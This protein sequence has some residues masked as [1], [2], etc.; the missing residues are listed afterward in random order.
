M[1]DEWDQYKAAPADEWA[2]YKKQTPSDGPW[3]ILTSLG[4]TLKYG[5]DTATA[6][7]QSW[8]AALNPYTIP[9][10]V[11]GDVYNAS[12]EQVKKGVQS[13]KEGHPFRGARQIFPGALP[14]VG[15]LI[16]NSSEKMTSGR[17]WEGATDLAQALI[18]MLGEEAA[19]SP[20]LRG[21]AKT[22]K[23]KTQGA[24]Q[25]AKAGLGQLQGMGAI[26]GELAQAAAGHPILGPIA[27]ALIGDAFSGFPM[28]RGAV[29]GAIDAK[30][31]P[32]ATPPPLPRSIPPIWEGQG[33]TGAPMPPMD[34]T[35]G[36]MPAPK[37]PSGRTP[38]A[39]NPFPRPETTPAPN[40][41]DSATAPAAASPT[42]NLTPEQFRRDY[43]VHFDIRP[44]DPLTR[45]D[46]MMKN[47]VTGSSSMAVPWD[48]NAPA[49]QWP[50]RAAKPG[51]VAY[52]FDKNSYAN[53]NTTN[54]KPG[55]KPVDYV[56][57][58]EGESPLD[59]L[60]RKSMGSSPTVNVD[61]SHLPHIGQEARD[62]AAAHES[63]KNALN[64][65][66]N[67]SKFLASKNW[68]PENLP[69][70][71]TPQNVKDLNAMVQE[72][73]RANKTNHSLFDLS[74][75]DKANA[76]LNLLRMVL[77]DTLA[78]PPQ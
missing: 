17:P 70:E 65:A 25:G 9:N 67:I 63:P 6:P 23:V 8:E 66:N 51:S 15:P 33:P 56:I 22:V 29:R 47:G 62:F 27:G 41:P 42:V 50:K 26:A 60:K 39:Y 40:P 35:I 4:N 34:A 38:G 20:A 10:K 59:A 43:A 14:M 36:P 31:P 71:V 54:L 7:L 45:V 18:S 30:V 44:G 55:A 77:R 68:T 32:P 21:A 48:E 76:S 5:W 1:A 73:N 75:P 78:N 12:A 58:R 61:V 13:T 3:G 19:A 46:S 11:L 24:A 64:K 2:Q 37:L 28:V 57:L 69:T 49:W 16:E 53:E 52:I 74:K 72:A